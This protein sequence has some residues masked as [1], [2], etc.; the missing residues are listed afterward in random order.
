M[1]IADEDRANISGDVNLDD[2]LDEKPS[3]CGNQSLQEESL[4]AD[5]LLIKI[6]SEL[7]QDQGTA[8]E[9]KEQQLESKDLG[10]YDQQQFD[11]AG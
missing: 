3:A 5:P 6:Q 4:K 1:T 8:E 10:Y 7:S 2:K 9:T 11:A